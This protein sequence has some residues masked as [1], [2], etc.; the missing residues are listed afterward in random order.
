[1]NLPFPFELVIMSKLELLHIFGRVHE[2]ALTCLLASL[3]APLLSSIKLFKIDVNNEFDSTHLMTCIRQFLE[4]TDTSLHVR[5]ANIANAPSLLG[6]AHTVKLRVNP[7]GVH[8]GTA[9]TSAL[10]LRIQSARDPTRS[11]DIQV[12]GTALLQSLPMNK[13]YKLV[14][15]ISRPDAEDLKPSDL[16]WVAATLPKLVIFE[17]RC[18][19]SL[20]VDPDLLQVISTM[21]DDDKARPVV[22]FPS[23]ET[24]T[25]SSSWPEPFKKTHW[26]KA[27]Q[28]FI[29]AA[30]SE[31]MLP[32]GISVKFKVHQEWYNA[33]TQKASQ[34]AHVHV[35]N[36]RVTGKFEG[37]YTLLMLSRLSL[38][39]TASSQVF[40]I[41]R[42][43]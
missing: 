18:D 22:P 19:R 29:D 32:G 17:G 13:L 15:N 20:G 6:L 16:W 11:L 1:M 2:A 5:T 38:A 39:L 28:S 37:V 10:A 41:L 31:Q 25:S 42:E 30:C 9:K 4:N 21:G 40:R 23:L 26:K 33:I 34:K 7:S 3:Q 14:I 27:L 24:F 35:H 36:S 8:A 12:L 43:D